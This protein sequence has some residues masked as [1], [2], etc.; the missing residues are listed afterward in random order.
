MKNLKT[1]W[2]AAAAGLLAVAVQA[3][4]GRSD[5]SFK[6][7]VDANYQVAHNLD[8]TGVAVST[9]NAAGTVSG[10][11]VLARTV[12]RLFFAGEGVFYGIT[13]SSGAVGD[14]AACW[15][16]AA[17]DETVDPFDITDATLVGAV[18]AVTTEWR[19]SGA[20]AKGGPPPVHIRKGLVCDST[21]ATVTGTYIPYFEKK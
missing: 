2:L 5:R 21:L 10:N 9:A 4:M 18:Q 14:W 6:L 7:P 15:D 3:Q 13:I 16:L 1:L 19:Y 8:F 20:G 11:M 12:S 17:A